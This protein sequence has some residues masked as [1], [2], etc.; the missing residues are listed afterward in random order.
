MRSQSRLAVITAGFFGSVAG[1]VALLVLI[2]GPGPENKIVAAPKE[3]TTAFPGEITI[4]RYFEY[5]PGALEISGTYV[6]F[7]SD[8][9][10]YP[11]SFLIEVFVWNTDGPSFT[12]GWYDAWADP[13][14]GT[15]FAYTQNTGKIGGFKAV[16]YMTDLGPNNTNTSEQVDTGYTPFVNAY[17][18]FDP[19]YYYDNSFSLYAGTETSANYSSV[20]WCRE[21]NVNKFWVDGMVA[22][23]V[24]DVEMRIF[25]ADGTTQVHAHACSVYGSHEFLGFTTVPNVQNEASLKVKFRYMK[26]S[27]WTTVEDMVVIE[28]NGWG[29]TP[30]P[31]YGWQ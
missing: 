27:Q 22:E 5:G 16:A 3:P 21:G 11:D 15:W 28:P 6:P 4:T 24:T 1:F 14:T 20:Y 23:D 8:A 17:L 2:L 13:A 31:A 29:N 25:K 7:A 19:L 26:N 12:G 30:W 10:V 9:N 18:N